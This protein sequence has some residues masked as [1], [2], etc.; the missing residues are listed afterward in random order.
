MRKALLS[1]CLLLLLPALATAAEPAPRAVTATVDSDG[2][3]RVEMVGG[4][5]FFDPYQVTV[6]VGVPVEL[7]VRKEGGMVPHDIVM[8]APEA[9]I[10]FEEKLET[11][12]KVIRFTPTKT[13]KYPFY[14]DKKLLFLESHREKG[15]EG[16]LEVVE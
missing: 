9:G 1:A 3:Q 16:I 13:G 7:T 14:C 8:R 15:M 4:G 2:V 5:Y 10:D 6:K 11:R 12:P